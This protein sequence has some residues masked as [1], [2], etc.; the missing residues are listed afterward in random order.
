MVVRAG[1][2]ESVMQ[3]RRLE[4][5]GRADVALSMKAVWRKIPSSFG[6]LRPLRPSTDL[7]TLIYTKESILLYSK[8]TGL[9][10]SL[11]KIIS[12]KKYLHGNI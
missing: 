5:Q 4:M 2:S 12:S 6:S 7:L 11:I 1:V 3:A 8:S 9:D 10:V